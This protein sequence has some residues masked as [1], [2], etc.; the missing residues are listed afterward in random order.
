MIRPPIPPWPRLSGSRAW[1][2]GRGGRSW[3]PLLPPAGAIPRASPRHP[4]ALELP[5]PPV[6]FSPATL[7]DRMRGRDCGGG[8]ECRSLSR[9][10]GSPPPSIAEAPQAP[11]LRG[12]AFPPFTMVVVP[13]ILASVRGGRPDNHRAPGGA[14]PGRPSTRSYVEPRLKKRRPKSHGWLRRPRWEYQALLRQG[15]PPKEAPFVLTPC[16]KQD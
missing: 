16:S 3:L 2:R 11:G 13:G 12:P 7:R 10:A 5:G 6:P 8:W 15:L 4:P 1:L 9:P 14:R